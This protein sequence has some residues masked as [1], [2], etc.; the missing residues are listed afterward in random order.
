VADIAGICNA[1][2]NVV[3]LMPHPEDHVVSL[4]NPLGN[5]GHLGLTLFKAL[6][7]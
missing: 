1:Y 3:G 5:N 2:G 7:Q 4:Q 6:I